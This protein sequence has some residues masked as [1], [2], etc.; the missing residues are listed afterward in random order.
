MACTWG[1]FSWWEVIVTLHDVLVDFHLVVVIEGWN[2]DEHL[3]KGA[4]QRPPIHLEG[5]PLVKHDLWRQVVW[6]TN[7]RVLESV[8]SLTATSQQ[9]C[10]SPRVQKE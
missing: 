8:L 1:A 3:I 2:A 10:I 9:Q 7:S 5:M 4:A 6:G